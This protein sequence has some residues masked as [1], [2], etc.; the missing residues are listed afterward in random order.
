MSTNKSNARSINK[1][2]LEGKI[3][4]YRYPVTDSISMIGDN[5]LMATVK[6][7]GYPYELADDSELYSNYNLF[8]TYLVSIGKD[9]AG[10]LGLWTYIDKREILVNDVYK[11][12][13]VFIQKFVDKY[14]ER[15]NTGGRYYE[16]V[17][18]ITLIYNYGQS[19][20]DDGIKK[21]D[22]V[23]K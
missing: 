11:S 8:R 16:S 17:Y 14:M 2:A 10:Q 21:L 5:K 4:H 22:S 19:S 18:Y 7:A 20:I 13:N 6:I 23:L 3:P 1:K 9:M 15:F 12:N